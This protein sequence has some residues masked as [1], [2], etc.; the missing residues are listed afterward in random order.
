[1][2]QLEFMTEVLSDYCVVENLPFMSASDIL[3]MYRSILTESQREWLRNY[4]EIWDII[5]ENENQSE[6]NVDARPIFS[7]I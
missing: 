6:Q 3:V 4:I 1:M 2:C 7:S 5:Q